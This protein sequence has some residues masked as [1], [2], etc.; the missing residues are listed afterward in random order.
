MSIHIDFNWVKVRSS[1][2]VVSR[3]SM[4][5]LYIKV[6]EA[7]VTRVVDRNQRSL[8]D[9]IVVPMFSIADWL[10]YNWWHLFHEVGNNGEQRQ[11]FAS[12]HDLAFAGGGIDTSP[13]TAKPAATC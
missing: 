3:L 6:D 1:P 2:D 4:A 5:E 13:M 7:I 8:R 9:R 11:D 12:R 10:V